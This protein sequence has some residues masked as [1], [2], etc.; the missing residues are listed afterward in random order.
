MNLIAILVYNLA[1]IAMFLYLIQ[2]HNWN[3][4]WF[5]VAILVIITDYKDK[6]SE[7]HTS[8]LQSH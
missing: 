8:E 3:P 6:R 7:E 1:I 5:L 4:W 2:F